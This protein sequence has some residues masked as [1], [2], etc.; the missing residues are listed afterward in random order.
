MAMGITDGQK[1]YIKELLERL[2]GDLADYTNKELED[3]TCREASEI[4][5]YIKDELRALRMQ[6][7]LYYKR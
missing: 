2:N 6:Q 4:I 1:S 3:L 7:A 5:D